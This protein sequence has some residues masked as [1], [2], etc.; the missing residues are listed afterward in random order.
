MS[1]ATTSIG[2]R[3]DS[4]CAFSQ[5]ITSSADRPS[6]WPSSPWPPMMSAKPECQVWASR[7]VIP[8]GSCAAARL[9]DPQDAHLP[10]K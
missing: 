5:A 8:S 2:A 1:I 4:G 10:A 7:T 6:T 3:H 9:I